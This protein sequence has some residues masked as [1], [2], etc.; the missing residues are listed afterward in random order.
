MT[1]LI[2]YVLTGINQKIFFDQSQFISVAFLAFS[3]LFSRCVSVFLGML[4]HLIL[5]PVSI[6]AS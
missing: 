6:F 4:L 2:S 1:F 5:S 3:L